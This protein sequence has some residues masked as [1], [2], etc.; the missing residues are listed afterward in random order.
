MSLENLRRQKHHLFQQFK[1]MQCE[2]ERKKMADWEERMRWEDIIWQIAY[3][4]WEILGGS[5]GSVQ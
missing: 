3:L 1:E 4:D 2:E 5:V